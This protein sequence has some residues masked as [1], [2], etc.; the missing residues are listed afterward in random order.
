MSDRLVYLSG[1]ELA[2]FVSLDE[3]IEVLERSLREGSV[4]PEA[5]SPRLFSDLRAGEFLLMP[6]E[7]GSY[8]GVKVVTVAPGN[9]AAGY[10]KIQGVYALFDSEHLR[11]LM[12]M[13]A[14]ELT[15]VRTPAITA[16]A[17][18]HMLAAGGNRSD[19]SRAK[20]H[21]LSVIGT[22]PQA[23]RHVLAI[24]AVVEVEEVLVIGR[25][26]SS[27]DA[28]VE[29][30]RAEPYRVRG[31]DPSDLVHSDLI[32]CAT[33]SSVPVLDDE[34]VA[35]DAVICAVGAHGLNRR[36]IP[37]ALTLRSDVVVEGRASAM[38]EAGNL[39]PARS[40]EEWSQ[41]PLSNLAELVAGKF[42]RRPGHPALYSGVGMAWEDLVV[43]GHIYTRWRE[44]EP[45]D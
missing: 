4:D 8:S 34:H 2:E 29:T 16:L 40:A 21:R 3:C 30:F 15:L 31:G 36:E 32:V 13:D 11:P 7:A 1:P 42:V 19:G 33:S 44:Q 43:A 37:A 6:T 5:D 25:R 39:I 26:S 20:V 28:V 27:A 12:L 24:A 45:T 9:P 38:R 23:L 22:G 14:A 10:P 18:R 35:P 41:Q 17:V